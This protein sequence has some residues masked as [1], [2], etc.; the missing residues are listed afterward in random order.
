MKIGLIAG[1]YKPYHAGHDGLVRLAAKECD[2]VHLYVS[3]SDRARPGE[4]PILGSDMA[5][6][7][8]EFIEPTLPENV[9]VT[10]GGSPIGN[11][12]KELGA[13]SEVGSEDMFF[14]YADPTDLVQN[15]TKDLFLKYSGNLMSAGQIKLRAVERS[16]TV[17]VS[18]TEMRSFLEKGDKQRFIGKLPRTI[19]GNAV[20]DILHATAK[21]P[22]KLKKTAGSV[23]KPA[24][25]KEPPK[26][27]GLLRSYIRLLIG[28]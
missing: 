23:R 12:W 5:R 24:A 18:G 28:R 16:S 15:F 27:E 3:V 9:K 6:I 10:Y 4:V 19:N 26:S 13:A 25:K 1:S 2:A 20:W 14:I 11:I 7:W 21:N 17:D 22:P 8:K